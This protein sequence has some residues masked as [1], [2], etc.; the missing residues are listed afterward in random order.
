MKQHNTYVNKWRNRRFE[1]AFYGIPGDDFNG[2]FD[3]PV[4][5]AGGRRTD[6]HIKMR[7]IISNGGGWEHV[8]VSLPH[9]CPTW[10]EM[11]MIKNLF[12]NKDETVIQ[13]HPAESEYVNAHEYCLH[14][15]R[16]INE[17]IPTPPKEFVG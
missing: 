13:Y 5:E 9:R 11:C 8:S 15:W 2:V 3:I 1:L 12:F 6:D 16:P 10:G 7:V 14:L 17:K 4:S